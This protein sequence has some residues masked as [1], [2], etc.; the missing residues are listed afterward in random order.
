MCY[1]QEIHFLKRFFWVLFGCLLAFQWGLQDLRSPTKDWTHAVHSENMESK[2][3]DYQ[4]IP[5]F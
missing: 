5:W 4:G 2:P 3:L 1:Q